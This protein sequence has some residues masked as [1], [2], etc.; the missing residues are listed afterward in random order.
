MIN[1]LFASAAVLLL[2]TAAFM[3]A[4]TNDRMANCPNR[5]GCICQPES[6]ECGGETAVMDCSGH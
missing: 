4:Q 1:K 2:V 6:Q 5:P 3:F